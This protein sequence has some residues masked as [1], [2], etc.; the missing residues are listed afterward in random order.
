MFGSKGYYYR[1][2]ICY[3]RLPNLKSVLEHRESNHISNFYGSTTMAKNLDK[4]PD[5][6]NPDF[7]CKSCEKGYRD[8]NAYRGH[9]RKVH[10]MVLKPL[11]YQIPQKTN[12]TPD[13]NDPNHNCKVCNFTYKRK[14]NYKDHCRYVHGLNPA[15][16]VNQ[17]SPSSSLTNLYCQTCDKRFSSSYCYRL[18]LFVIH[19]V[20][21]RQILQKQKD[22]LPN[23]NDPNNYCRACQKTYSSK[24]GYR[25]HLRLVHQMILPLSRVNNVNHKQLPDPY[26]RNHYCSVCK[27]KYSQ[28]G[29]YR[30]HCRQ[31]HL[32]V[33]GHHSIV[34]PNAEIN[35]NDPDFYCSQCERSF[36]TKVFF[37][38]HL[39][40]IHSTM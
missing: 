16:F 30:Q 28:A 32:M 11:R 25:A 20:D 12:A 37:K 26:N 10:Y 19:K 38:R 13:P 15:E 14:S 39:Q 7:Y 21:I 5:L 24:G 35:V 2:D 31:A 34:N 6:Y 23:V 29:V 9:L 18:H 33:L 3:Q 22:T 8:R 4:E 17:A 40:R 27:K 1:C 36:S